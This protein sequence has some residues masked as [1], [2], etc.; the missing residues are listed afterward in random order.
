MTDTQNAPARAGLFIVLE[1]GDGAG[2]SSQIPELA[3]WLTSLG[4][5]VIATREP[6]GTDIGERIRPL[7]L[8]HGQGEVDARTE[9]LLYAAARAAH[10]EQRILPHLRAGG[11]VICDRFVDSSVAYQSAGRELSADE[12]LSINAFAT[13]GL[14]PD[15]TVLLDIDPAEGRRRRTAGGAEDRLE[16]E[17][18]EF[19]A[20]PRQA[21]L[22]LAA[23]APER[24][25]VIDATLTPREVQ[26]RIQ[27][28]VQ[29]LLEAREDGREGA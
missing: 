17:P 16:A 8:E 23:A 21:F 22:D 6:G 19:H 9:A 29:R 25:E 27:T 26:A 1:G 24:Y 18:D 5:E 11:T 20:R 13:Q 3:T 2:K 15:L 12:V 4:H 28:R 14:T 7:V 10:V